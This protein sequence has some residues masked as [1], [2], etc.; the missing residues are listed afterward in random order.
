MKR[1]CS[2]VALAFLA[3][4]VCAANGARAQEAAD[5]SRTPDQTVTLFSDVKHKDYGRAVFSFALGVRGDE[6]PADKRYTHDL[7]YGGISE[8]GDDH[9]FDVPMCGPSRTK[10]K[11]L[12]ELNW[13]DVYYVPVLF[14]LPAPNCS[15]VG[16]RFENGK[17][18]E[19]SPEGVN[20]RAV[21]GH[22]YVMRVKDSKSD[23][24]VMFRV[25]SFEPEGKCTISW[26]RVPS[27]DADQ[28]A[29]DS[30]K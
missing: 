28:P 6:E 30:D 26:K 8:N 20:V 4:V 7:R 27:P 29:A 3:L 19:I 24:Y 1:C 10:L 21:A 13:S 12:G 2:R 18:V 15:G 14:A 16:W 5:L 17:V 25:E 23:F 9:W 22:M 11:D